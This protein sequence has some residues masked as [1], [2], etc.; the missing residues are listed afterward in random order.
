ML[1]LQHLYPLLPDGDWVAEAPQPFPSDIP[2]KLVS[3]LWFDPR[4]RP[5]E[6]GTL[7][8]RRF[9]VLSP[10]QWNRQ[11]GPDFRQ[12]VIAYADGERCRGDVEIHRLTSGWAAHRHHLDTRY[13]QVIL[14]VVLRHDRMAAEVTRA[15]GQAVPQVALEA[16]LPRPLSALLG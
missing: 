12:A 11:A 10:G 9:T 16:W 13:N 6:L 2:E 14:H 3:C 1:A 4:W 7:D 5:S 8:G 15:D